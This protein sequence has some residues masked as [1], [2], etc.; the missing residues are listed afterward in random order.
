M[1]F[2]SL[3]RLSLGR[4]MLLWAQVWIGNISGRCLVTDSDVAQLKKSLWRR[5][6]KPS[7]AHPEFKAADWLGCLTDWQAGQV[8]T[9]RQNTLATKRLQ[10]KT[11]M[12]LSCHAS[13]S[14]ELEVRFWS[15]RMADHA[16][17]R[18]TGKA[19]L[20]GVSLSSSKWPITVTLFTRVNK[21]N[22]TS[23]SVRKWGAA[24]LVNTSESSRWSHQGEGLLLSSLKSDEYHRDK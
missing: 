16:W 23:A 11:V 6:P 7:E 9:T 13:L 4:P 1:V 21:V 15:A 3:L 20:P 5:L 8:N 17:H 22:K 10:M 19:L 14:V 12:N 18:S 24:S 2:L